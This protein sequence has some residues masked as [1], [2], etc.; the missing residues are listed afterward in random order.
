MSVNKL[1]NN[2]LNSIMLRALF[3]GN[4]LLSDH[5]A[6]VVEHLVSSGRYQNASEVLRDG[7]RIIRRREAE[8]ALRLEAGLVMRAAKPILTKRSQMGTLAGEGGAS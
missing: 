5:Q 6:S 4:V 3:G 1:V 7:L 2:N 8:D